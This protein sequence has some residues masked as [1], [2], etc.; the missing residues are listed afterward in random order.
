MKNN[1]YE[2][3][4]NHMKGFI[5][6]LL[7]ILI[8]IVIIVFFHFIAYLDKAFSGNE[9]YSGDDSDIEYWNEDIERSDGIRNGE[10]GKSGNLLNEGK[11]RDFGS[12]PL[13]V[14]DRKEAAEKK[15]EKSKK[16]SNYLKK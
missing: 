6:G 14:K 11:Q 12:K 8:I 9:Y 1:K 3:M 16:S 2:S 7:F 13:N 4:G 15:E 10:T 5:Q